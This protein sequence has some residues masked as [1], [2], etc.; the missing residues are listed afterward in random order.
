[1]TDR[2]RTIRILGWDVGGTASAALVGTSEGEILARDQWAS[3]AR[4]GFE[5][6]L[7]DFLARAEP[8]LR[9]YPDV[10]AMGVSVGGPMNAASGT[11]LSP[12]HL[13]GWDDIPL[14]EILRERL[15]LA[16]RVEHDAA[17]CL[18]AEWFWGAARGASHAIYLTC[19][20]GCGAGILLDGRILYGPD[21]QSPETG[22]IRLADDGPEMFG[23][24]G[25][26]ESFCSGEGIGKLAAYMFPRR[27]G[28]QADARGLG[29]LCNAGDEQARRV[30]ARSARMTGRLCALLSD[31]FSP[32]VIVLGSLARYFGRWWLTEVTEEFHREA[33]AINAAA[34]ITTPVLGER[35]QDL[36]AI[37][38][39]VAVTNGGP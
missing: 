35:L 10:S 23:K 39:A 38:A 6:M 24:C 36:S 17:A 37:A 26:A 14:G 33:L 5:A 25:C 27:F 32:Q 15:G 30:L 16:V 21:G 4:R 19:G 9:R 8:L 11:I 31:I 29:E 18:L 20:T 28:G 3:G 7:A 22:H 13:P 34:R 2:S 1:M 12:P